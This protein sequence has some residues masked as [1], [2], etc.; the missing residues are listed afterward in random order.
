MLLTVVHSIQWRRFNEAPIRESG[1]CCDQLPMVAEPA[2][3][4]EAPI[5]ESGKYQRPVQ[6]VAAPRGFNEAPIRESGK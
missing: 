4:N 5:R 2:G 1:K 3:F 6:K